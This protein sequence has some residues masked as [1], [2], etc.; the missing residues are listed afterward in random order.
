[1]VN[2]AIHTVDK[3][4]LANYYPKVGVGSESI[5]ILRASYHK[6]CLLIVYSTVVLADNIYPKVIQSGQKVF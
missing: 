5:Y 1:M 3:S 4:F 6:Y 2:I